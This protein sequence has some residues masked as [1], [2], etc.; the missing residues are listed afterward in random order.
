MVAIPITVIWL[1]SF[2]AHLRLN[3][4]PKAT[5]EPASLLQR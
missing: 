1:I 5:A 4:D 3:F 2:R